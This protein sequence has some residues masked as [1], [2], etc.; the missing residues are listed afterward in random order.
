M[1]GSEG[2][3]TAH[4]KFAP[5]VLVG[6]LTMIAMSAAGEPISA[7]SVDGVTTRQDQ[8]S[9]RPAAARAGLVIAEASFEIDCESI[10]TAGAMRAASRA[11]ADR[12]SCPTR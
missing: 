12:R 2:M 4:S 1:T 7:L 10:S 3:S 8:T 5:L 6:A 11:T 9:D